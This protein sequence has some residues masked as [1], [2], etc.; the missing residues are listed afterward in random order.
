MSE[1]M[2]TYTF[3]NGRFHLPG[4]IIYRDEDDILTYRCPHCGARPVPP[5]LVKKFTLLLQREAIRLHPIHQFN[6]HAAP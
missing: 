5:H 3:K 1:C 2:Q 4:T 6:Q